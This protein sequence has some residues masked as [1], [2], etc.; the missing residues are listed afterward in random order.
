ML[1]I[2]I[3]LFKE[4]ILLPHM[5]SGQK[6]EIKKYGDGLEHGHGNKGH[7]LSVSVSPLSLC[8]RH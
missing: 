1:L 7:L 6:Q 5:C 3:F 8:F 2:R 4:L